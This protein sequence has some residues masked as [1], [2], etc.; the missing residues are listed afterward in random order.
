MVTI[1]KVYLLC[2]LVTIVIVMG[3][4]L[5]GDWS[6][7]DAASGDGYWECPIEP[8]S[9]VTCFLSTIQDA[10]FADGQNGWAVGDSGLILRLRNGQWGQIGHPPSSH[11][12]GVALRDVD[13]GWAIGISADN[14]GGILQLRN[15]QWTAL[16]PV[17]P[18]SL[19]DVAING[20]TAWAV[21]ANGV[22]L[23][24]DGSEWL[25]LGSPTTQHLYA[26]ALT[27]ST[28]GWA[29]GNNGVLLRLEGGAWSVAASPTNK[30]LN[31]LA[32]V[33]QD[34]GWAVG[35]G[36]TLLHLTAGSWSVVTAP[37]GTPDLYSV[38][39]TDAANGWAVGQAGAILRLSSGTWTTATN[40]RSN[41]SL[42]AVVNAGGDVWAFGS[43]DRYSR[44]TMLALPS[45][46]T[47]W[48]WYNRPYMDPWKIQNFTLAPG[49]AQDGFA[50]ALGWDGNYDSPE[51]SQPVA[52]RMI[53][54]AWAQADSLPGAAQTPRAV[55]LVD[56]QNGW[57][58]GNGGAV[59]RLLNGGWERLASSPTTKD[60][61][62]LA[63][64]GISAGWAVGKAGT[65]L[66]L[67]GG[68]WSLVAAIG[69]EDLNAIT[70]SG[71]GG[72]VVG[73]G[74]VIGR[75]VAALGQ[76]ARVGSPT[77]SN[78]HSV[79]LS[80]PTS[81]YAVGDDVTLRLS[82]GTWTSQNNVDATGIALSG[83]E[84]GWAVSRRGIR[85]LN[86]GAWTMERDD[87]TNGIQVVLSSD[88]EG[89]AV[90][91]AGKLL[92][93]HGGQWYWQSGAPAW[94]DVALVDA[95]NG[96]AVG[97]GGAIWQL[98]AGTW[99]PAYSPTTNHLNAV[100][101]SGA[102]AGWAVGGSDYYGRSV[103]LQLR[104]GIWSAT[105]APG[106]GALY[107]VAL[108]SPDDGWAVRYGFNSLRLSGGVW[109][110]VGNTNYHLL[111]LALGGP[112]SGWAV[113]SQFLKLQNGIWGVAT[114][115]DH[116]ALIN[117][118]ELEGVN[119]GW[120][121]GD[122]Y[123][124]G[125][126]LRLNSGAWS[127]VNTPQVWL[128]G[129]GLDGVGGGWAVGYS[130]A[131]LRLKDNVWSTA[132]SPTSV[133]LTEVAL[134]GANAGWVV[135]DN[136]TILRY[137]PQTGCQG[138][139]TPTPT[140]TS[141]ATRPPTWTPTPGPSPTPTVT[142]HLTGRTVYL[143]MAIRLLA[144]DRNS[145]C[146]IYEPNDSLSLAWGP[147][148]N[149]VDIT[150]ALCEGDPE[151]YYQIVLPAATTLT[152]ELAELPIGTDYDLFL[153]GAGASD[154]LSE[155]RNKGAAPEQ[156]VKALAAGRYYVRVYPYEGRSNHLYRLTAVWGSSQ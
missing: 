78:L 3:V 82:E 59:W 86:E 29:V 55:A 88:G 70:L 44:A 76:W 20:D 126:V 111:A 7:T 122:Y 74:G 42:R 22:T 64:T 75:Y 54:G 36:G 18:S 32:L 21:G 23:F 102:S 132:P 96:W 156:I 117:D 34:E 125:S 9:R 35:A 123:A 90:S 136:G 103:P 46:A 98:T 91:E 51:F 154:A 127:S 113:G 133:Y 128:L 121:V 149:G 150:A 118:V 43:D 89:W 25:G 50:V 120:A 33:S 139:I 67:D 6:Q 124:S 53:G 13:N 30:A 135:G 101:L 28:S 81:G 85:R 145:P 114:G 107:D 11:L 49:S 95:G 1:R 109:S 45:D 8:E 116:D 147:L 142:P 2:W 4:G 15:G 38:T 152:I 73:A 153:Y 155:S 141:T 48:T 151:D 62:A 140:P 26:V 56:A 83:A 24:Y 130:G 12:Y 99:Q 94:S 39:L 97:G 52:V 5:I 148:L 10:A 115:P 65:I 79:A 77:T 41:R 80:S 57:A 100:A 146:R 105:T 108:S 71:N 92:W 66:R 69:N 144:S 47:Q 58:V 31:G 72:A 61:N 63:L 60:L 19:Y 17:T 16:A 68:T 110:E 112:D 87:L 134:S 27:S 137:C 84:R 119:T 37:P 14:R 104:D 40:P 138:A 131:L 143:P 129:L 106:Q 93:L